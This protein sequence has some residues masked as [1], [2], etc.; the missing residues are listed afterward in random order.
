ME[1]IKNYLETMF[2]NFPD[3]M[4]IR[5]AKSELLSMSE[6]KY[7][8]LIASGMPKNEVV[9][10]IISELGTP[11]ELAESLG[12][13]NSQQRETPVEIVETNTV[14][15][16][17][18]TLD[19][20]ADYVGDCALSKMILGLGIL[21][22]IISPAGPVLGESFRY[23]FGNN[24]FSEMLGGLGVGFLFLSTAIGVGFI[25]LSGHKMKEWKFLK[26][27]LCAVDR[28][29]ENF[30][31]NELEN[32][33]LRKSFSLVVGIGLCII[34]VVPVSIFGSMSAPLFFTA[35]LGPAMIFNLTGLGVYFI[36]TSGSKSHAYEHLLSLNTRMAA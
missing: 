24:A 6:D 11:E 8:E 29:T 1:T 3:T 22:C 31:R 20:A 9:G 4:E 23:I 30:L 34:S 16:R 27:E 26:R 32:V 18:V 14:Y 19:E 2:T 36:I 10:T 5:R 21:F 15:R 13:F 7:N 25:I 17:L 33:R 12:F 28:E 35:G